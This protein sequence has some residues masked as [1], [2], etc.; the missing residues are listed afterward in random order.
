MTA[1][2]ANTNVLQLEG[3]KNSLTGAFLNSATVTVTVKGPDGV[4]V[5]GETWPLTMDYV[6]S[7]N[8]NYRG[9]LA[10]SLPFTKREY[11]AHVDANGG[12]GLIGHWEFAFKP[13][14]RTG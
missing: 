8:G 2:I 11:V 4:N 13:Q 3:L 10:H 6:T 14:V 5:S 9:I 7:S 1:F 12:A